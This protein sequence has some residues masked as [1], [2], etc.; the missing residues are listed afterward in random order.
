MQSAFDIAIEYVH[1]RKQFGKPIGSFQ[2]IQGKVAGTYIRQ[3]L[4]A[5]VTD[6]NARYVHK[7]E[8]ITVVCVRCWSRLRQGSN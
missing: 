2:L 7:T 5:P 6:S 8:R 4:S 3:P 1:D